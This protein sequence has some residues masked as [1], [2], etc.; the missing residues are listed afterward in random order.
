MV[1]LAGEI[2]LAVKR[3]DRAPARTRAAARAVDAGVDLYVDLGR[4]TFIDSTGLNAIV[5]TTTSLEA[6]RAAPAPLQR[7]RRSCCG[8]WS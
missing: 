6:Q 2:D 7:S 5:R 1:A 4:V 3:R 8:C